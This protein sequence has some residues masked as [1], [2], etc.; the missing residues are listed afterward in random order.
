MKEEKQA[1]G[2]LVGK[3][4]SAREAHSYPL[5]SVP[6]ALSTEDKELRQGSKG[7]LR[8]HMITEAEAVGELAP[9][10]QSR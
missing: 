4:T 6:L 5:T 3:T 1:F 10:R 2:S 9:I 8:N 7:T